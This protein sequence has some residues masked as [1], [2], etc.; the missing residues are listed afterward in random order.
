MKELSVEPGFATAERADQRVSA[1]K[2]RAN[3]ID[4]RRRGAHFRSQ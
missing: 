1:R 4:K 2:L 3:A